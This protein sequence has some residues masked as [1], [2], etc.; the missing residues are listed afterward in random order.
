MGFDCGI[1]TIGLVQGD[2][3]GG[4]LEAALSCNFIIAERGVKMGLPEVIFNL[5]PG[6][7]A[8]SLLSRRLGMAMAER[9]IFSGRLYSAEEMYELGVVDLVVDPGCGDKAVRDYIADPRNHNAR[10]AIFRARQ[11]INPITLLSCGTLPICGW[12]LR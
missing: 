3:L 4:G 7:G 2:A 11:R 10:Q 6:M 1:V 8:Y 5:F 12:I 9:I